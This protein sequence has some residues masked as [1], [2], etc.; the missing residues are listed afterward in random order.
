VK[1]SAQPPSRRAAF[2]LVELL[3]ALALAVVITGLILT[4]LALTNQAR[5][6]QA[7]RAGCRAVTSRAL[8]QLAQDLERTFLFPKREDTAFLL[9][10]GAAASNA[11][12]E[13][14]FARTAAAPGESDHRWAEVARVTYRLLEENFT[15]HTLICASRALAGPAAFQPPV[16]NAVI[17][18]LAACEVLLFDGKEW[19][20]TWSA[21][22]NSTNPAPRA[23]RLIL[24]A[25]RGT[26]RHS[27][28]TEVFIPI[29]FKF[30][31]PKKDKVPGKD[32]S[33]IK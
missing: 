16:T 32:I 30:E 27:T 23:A 20:D 3:V 12:W 15:N 7:E 26:A 21:G 28:T 17:Q 22:G 2:T 31:P 5:R 13:L 18:G 33:E 9:N 8:Q 1:P 25:Q 19:K 10:R 29:S 11:V 24:A 14:T 6:A 4:T